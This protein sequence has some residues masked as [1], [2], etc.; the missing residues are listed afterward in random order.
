MTT[1][2]MFD[3]HDGERGGFDR[4]P[5]AERRHPRCKTAPSRQSALDALRDACD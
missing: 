2:K 4:I 5:E 3:R 1:K